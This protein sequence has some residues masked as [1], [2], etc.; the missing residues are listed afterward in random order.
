MTI[1][2]EDCQ[3]QVKDSWHGKLYELNMLMLFLHRGV[4]RKFKFLLDRE[5]KKVGKFDDLKFQY[6]SDEKTLYQFYQLKHRINAETVKIQKEDLFQ[7]CGDFSLIKYFFSYQDFKNNKL[8]QNGS[9]KSINICTNIGIDFQDFSKNNI[10]VHQVNE[11]HEILYFDSEEPTRWRFDESI[12]EE[13]SPILQNYNLTRL[14]RR[15]VH[16]FL[17]HKP[18]RHDDRND[19]F[20]NYHSILAH[21]VIDIKEK[22]FKQNFV[23]GKNLS[24]EADDFRSKFIEEI[25]KQSDKKITLDNINDSIKDRVTVFKKPVGLDLID[26]FGID[27]SWPTDGIG[28]T[29]LAELAKH[30]IERFL[31]YISIKHDDECDIFYHYYGA[32]AHE[33]IDTK[34]KLFKKKFID[35]VNLSD[36][37]DI[38]RLAFIEELK[39]QTKEQITL[40]NI[41]DSIRRKVKI[42]NNKSVGLNIHKEFVMRKATAWPINVI[43]NVE[44]IDYLERLVL[45]I[46]Q[47][48]E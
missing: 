47:P 25:R 21:E 12:V 42:F 32:L 5:I 40:A 38:F 37:A 4:T 44:I 6:E 45:A 34:K 41:N 39:N 36:A 35:C 8:Y 30:F 20:Y 23:E 28:E 27:T 29:Q 22:I 15:L 2:T 31:N 13:L 17:D 26:K 48:N 43:T 24:P 16:F 9:I 14:A 46:N 11:N 7:D 10:K 3:D 18:I 1:Q 33:V 19:I